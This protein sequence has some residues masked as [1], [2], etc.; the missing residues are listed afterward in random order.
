VDGAVDRVRG[1]WVATGAEWRYDAD[2]Y[3]KVAQVRQDEQRA[4]REYQTTT[5]CR[6]RFLRAQLDDPGARDCGRCDNCGGLELSSDVGDEAVSAARS[7]LGRPGV[8]LDPRRMW[9]TTMPGLGIDVRGKLPAAEQAEVG[10]VVARFTDLGFGPRLRSLLAADVADAPPPDDLIK[11]CVQVLAAWD[12][13][14]RPAAIVHIGSLRRPTLIAE[15]ASRLAHIGRLT[16]LGGLPHAGPSVTA[17][18]N[19][20]LRLREVWN[21]YELSGELASQLAGQ[22]VLLVDDLV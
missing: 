5:G 6:M 18:S 3:T 15:L 19:S 8:P 14:E 13:A 4:M 12:W 7:A 9:P 1:G 21:A 11:V 20:A 2:R 22:S 16:D 17:R 10:R